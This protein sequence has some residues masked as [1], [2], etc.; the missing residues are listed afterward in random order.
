M[1]TN[2]QKWQWERCFNGKGSI[3][4]LCYPTIEEHI[5][6]MK[7]LWNSFHEDKKPVW[8]SYKEIEDYEKKMLSY[9]D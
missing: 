6:E 2:R 3:K 1:R 7:K 5:F 8:L 9:E 4:N